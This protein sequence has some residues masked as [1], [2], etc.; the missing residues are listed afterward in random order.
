MA[1]ILNSIA[2]AIVTYGAINIVIKL[3]QNTEGGGEGNTFIRN[4][5][6]DACNIMTH[7]GHKF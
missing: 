2:R 5:W 1:L 7:E 6:N 3:I 4:F